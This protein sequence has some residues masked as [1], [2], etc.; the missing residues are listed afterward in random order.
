MSLVRRHP[1]ITFFVLAY[2]L[3]WSAWPMWASGLYPIAPV[4]SFAPFLA[5][6]VV[7]AITNGKSGIGGLL[8]RMVCWRVGLRWYAVALLLPAGITVAA[9]V[10]NVLLG[11]QPPSSVEL[12]GWRGLLLGFAVALLIPGL[13]GAWEE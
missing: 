13:G 1:L 12:G 4:F 6:L 3:T 10:I 2:A 7:L 8:R 9:V 11:A 5:A